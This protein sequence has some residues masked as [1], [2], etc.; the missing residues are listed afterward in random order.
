MKHEKWFKQAFGTNEWGLAD[1]PAKISNVKSLVH[2]RAYKRHTMILNLPKG[3]ELYELED[4]FRFKGTADQIQ[5]LSIELRKIK[6]L[7]NGETCQ[8]DRLTF[9]VSDEV[10]Y[11]V[12]K[13]TIQLPKQAWGIMASKFSEVANSWEE[14]PFDFNDCAYLSPRL[15]VDL[16]VELIGKPNPR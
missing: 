2:D 7:S 4:K 11:L 8:L 1:F 14:S 12:D 13:S 6:N 15:Q 3:I 10:P 9:V 5:A 16:G